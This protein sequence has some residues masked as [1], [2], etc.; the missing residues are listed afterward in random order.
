MKGLLIIAVGLNILS[1]YA[2]D[3]ELNL[4][5][6]NLKQI[7]TMPY[8]PELSGDSLFW[9]VVKE[10]MTAVPYL[11]DKLDDTTMTEASVANFGGNYTVADIAYEAILIIIQGLPTLE[12]AEDPLNPEPRDGYWGYWNYTRRSYENRVKFKNRVNEWYTKNKGNLIWIEYTR[13][14]RTAPDWKFD[15]NRHPLGGYYKLKE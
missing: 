13:N 10:G 8:N 15:K 14:F 4:K 5:T 6:D 12:F 11:I 2:Q 3:S 9:V 7:T 1:C